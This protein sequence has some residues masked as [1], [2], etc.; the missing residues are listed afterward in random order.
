VGF[1]VSW[2]GIRFFAEIKDGIVNLLEIYTLNIEPAINEIF[3]KAEK[4]IVKLDPMMVQT[5]QNA[6]ASLSQSVGPLISTIFSKVIEF[7]SSSIFFI[8]G[9]FLSIIFA[10]ISYLF[11]TMGLL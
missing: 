10:V 8:P 3:N 4:L 11:F 6:A 7:I 9:L 1:L 2:I 5:I